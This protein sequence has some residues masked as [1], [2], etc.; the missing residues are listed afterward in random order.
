M[1]LKTLIVIILLSG[2]S[3]Y[4]AVPLPLPVRPVLPNVQA[5]SMDCLADKTFDTLRKRD[6]LWE[7]HAD[8]L[9]GIIRSTH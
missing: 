9:E 6:I 5:Q 2:C 7:I 4:Q 1:N 3:T 8:K